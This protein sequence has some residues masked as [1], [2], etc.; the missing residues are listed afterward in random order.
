MDV[1]ETADKILVV[2]HDQSL[3]RSCGI[4]KKI[5]D[6]NYADLPPFQEEIKLDFAYRKST[7]TN[8]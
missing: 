4:D 1:C 2:H 3:K 6:Y 7:P 8:N 5:S